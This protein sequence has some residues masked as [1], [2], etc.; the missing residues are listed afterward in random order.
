[1]MEYSVTFSS[2]AHHISCK[3]FFV[4][5][6]ILCV[7]YSHGTEGLSADGLA[8]LDFKNGLES[9][10]TALGNWRASDASPCN[11][12][13][14]GCSQSGLVTSLVVANGGLAGPISPSLGKLEEL[15]NLNLTQ[16]ML[17]GSIPP[18]LGNCSHLTTLVLDN[19]Q[20]TGSIPATLGKLQALQT[21]VL[22]TNELTGEIPAEL[23]N[24]TSLQSLCIASNQLHGSVP[25]GIY[26]ISNLRQLLVDS[27]NLTG[28][29]TEGMYHGNN[30]YNPFNLLL[31]KCVFFFSFQFCDVGTL[32]TIHGRI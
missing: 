4:I 25:R 10:G 31:S 13:G 9:Q 5:V 28:D 21:L 3:I 17:S 30:H 23:A 24:C 16:N 14:V 26:N 6:A 8:L 11:W 29:I 27:N 15:Q 20:L 22:I 1:M 18:E 2:L 12:E 19:N 7:F 32:A